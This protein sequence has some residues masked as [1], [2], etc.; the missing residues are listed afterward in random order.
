MEL[1]TQTTV[2]ALTERSGRARR[3]LALLGIDYCC[4]PDRSLAE[5]ARAASA[6]PEETLALLV[7][8][9]PPAKAANTVDWSAAPLPGITAHIATAHH[10]RARRLLVELLEDIEALTS[11]HPEQRN[12]HRL[13]RNALQQLAD[14]LIPHMVKEERFIFPYIDSMLRPMGPDDS[15]LVPLFGTIEYPLRSI[16]HDHS[17]DAALLETIMRLSNGFTPPAGAC[18]RQVRFLRNVADLHSDL[19]SHIQLE[20]DVLFPRAV[21]MEQQLAR[22]GGERT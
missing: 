8:G 14:D 9:V 12:Q 11:S 20:N 22:R 6:D 4:R 18:D 17:E 16:R 13:L 19:T 15:I 10:R 3:V 1:T 5:A 2:G 21:A 7:A